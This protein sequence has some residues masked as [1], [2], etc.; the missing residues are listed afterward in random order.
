MTTAAP[1]IVITGGGTGGHLFPAAA[2]AEELAER[3]HEVKIITDDRG[4]R[5][6]RIFR[7]NPVEAIAS[8]RVTESG[9]PPAT[10][11]T[12]RTLSRAWAYCSAISAETIRP[13]RLR[14]VW[15]DTSRRS[16]QPFTPWACRR[17]RGSDSESTA[18]RRVTRP[19]SSPGPATSRV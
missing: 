10:Q 4:L 5:F 1:H 9:L 2:V 6:A 18:D 13:S 12:S 17:A 19:V 14:P 7:N 15:A 8:G 16:P 11:T 3:G